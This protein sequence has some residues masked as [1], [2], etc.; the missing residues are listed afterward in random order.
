MEPLRVAVCEDRREEREALLAMLADCAEANDPAVFSSG[1]A[2]LAAY[3]PGAFDLLLMDIYLDGIT[4]V[5]TV[6]QVRQMGDAVPVA[7]LT[8]SPDHTADGYR[9]S[10]LM[11]LKKPVDRGRLEEMLELAR[12]KRDNAPALTV[13]RGGGTARLPLSRI[14]CLEQQGRQV[15]ISLQGGQ[16][17]AVYGKLTDL[18]PQL[19][20]RPF[21]RSHK[22]YLVHLAQVQ[23][24]DQELRC[25]VLADGENVPIRRDLMG[26]ARRAW[27]DFLFARTR[28]DV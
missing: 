19:E 3:R 8:T 27:E 7:F 15:L 5:E 12:L 6:E 28:G 10:T 2:L 18:L 4:G 23:R 26:K 1:E 13:S 17:A 22:S 9:L 16:T 24:I 20:A 21:F 14:L 25:F 11:Y